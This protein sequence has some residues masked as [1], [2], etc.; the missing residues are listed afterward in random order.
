MSFLGRSPPEKKR[1]KTYVVLRRNGAVKVGVEEGELLEDILADT[2]DLA[3][4]EERGHTGADAKGSGD[5]TALI[6]SIC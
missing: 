3:E 5:G 2:G 6:G 4:E 1:K